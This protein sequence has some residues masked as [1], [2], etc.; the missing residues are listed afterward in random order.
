MDVIHA[1]NISRKGKIRHD[2][3]YSYTPHTGLVAITFRSLNSFKRPFVRKPR[4]FYR[5]AMNAAAVD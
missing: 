3:D 1:S 2:R 4:G 5:P